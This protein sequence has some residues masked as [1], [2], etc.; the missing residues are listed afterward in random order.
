M[1]NNREKFDY[2]QAKINALDPNKIHGLFF[3][4][5]LSWHNFYHSPLMIASNLLAFFD[6]K[7]SVIFEDKRYV[8]HHVCHVSRFIPDEDSVF[9]KSQVAK[10]FEATLVG[11]QEHDLSDKLMAAD[12][13]C[14]IM[15]LGDVNKILAKAFEIEYLCQPYSKDSAFFAGIKFLNKIFK[16]TKG[17]FCSL[18]FSMFLKN[19]GYYMPEDLTEITPPD[20]W[21][22]RPEEKLKFYDSKDF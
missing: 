21:R 12:A 10:I 5:E 11:M 18:L 4:Y 2:I 7:Q 14:W 1:A 20:A 19:Q 15:T 17:L 22:M 6:K 16:L 9:G 8:I 13:T 3:S